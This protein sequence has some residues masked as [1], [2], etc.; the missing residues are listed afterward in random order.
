MTRARWASIQEMNNILLKQPNF[1]ISC[2][3]AVFKVCVINLNRYSKNFTYLSPKET[4]EN[5]ADFVDF[6]NDPT[7]GLVG[8]NFVLHPSDEEEA[9]Y[10]HMVS[11]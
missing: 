4:G 3:V 8:G 11:E 5:A 10:M 2:L 1:H 7:F 9:H 6:S